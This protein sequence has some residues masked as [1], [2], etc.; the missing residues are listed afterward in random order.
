[1][2]K[3]GHRAILGKSHTGF[4]L[5]QRLAR[6][7][8]L[9][10]RLEIKAETDHATSGIVTSLFS[11][12]QLLAKSCDSDSHAESCLTFCDPM[13]C[14]PLGSSFS[15]VSQAGVLEWVAMPSSRGS[16]CT[17]YIIR[18]IKVYGT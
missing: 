16:S 13:D 12:V 2:E 15:G 11:F 4:S 5:I 10:Q 7:M 1:M 9:E 3:Y 18:C 6:K 8:C 14:S 17:K